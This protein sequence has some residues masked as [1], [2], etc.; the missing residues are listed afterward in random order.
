VPDAYQVVGRY[1]VRADRVRVSVR[2]VRNE[3]GRF[4]IGSIQ[5]A[6]D[7]EIGDADLGR[8]GRCEELFEEF[9]MVTE[10]V[11]RGV[12]VEVTVGIG[13]PAPA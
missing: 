7:P 5:V 9:C 3:V 1:T 13:H 11:R 8:L 12:P 4:R 2:V 10:S 6:L